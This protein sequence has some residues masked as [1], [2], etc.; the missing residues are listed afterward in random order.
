MDALA[1][2]VVRLLAIPLVAVVLVALDRL[3]AAVAVIALDALVVLGVDQD[4]PDV[5]QDVPQ[6]AKDVILVRVVVQAVDQAVRMDQNPAAQ[7]VVQ[8]VL[9][10][11]THPVLDVVDV[12]VVVRVAAQVVVA[13]LD[14]VKVD[15]VVSTV[16]VVNHVPDVWAPA[17]DASRAQAVWVGVTGLAVMLALVDVVQRVRDAHRVVVVQVVPMVEHITAKDVH[18]GVQQDVDLH[19]EMAAMEVVPVDV[20]DAPVVD[21]D[22]LEGALEAA[23]ISVLDAP[24]VDLVVQV[25]VKAAMLVAPAN[26]LLLV[27]ALA[28]Q[29][30]L[31]IVAEP[32]MVKQL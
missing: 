14:N 18:L 9:E 17:V 29:H 23:Q 5:Q 3:E 15:L 19:V 4:V 26:V 2:L 30:V 22:A 20:P 24:V 10:T 27:V 13:A 21:Q 12:P 7:D 1:V 25:V 31:R 8:A 28:Q 32:A 11:A 6:D 16:V